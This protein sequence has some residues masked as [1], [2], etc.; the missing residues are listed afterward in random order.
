M[1]EV[2]YTAQAKEAIL[3]LT[4]KDRAQIEVAI[5]RL[6]A[7]PSLGKRLTQQLS[8]FYSYR[9]GVY[10]IIYKTYRKE[11]RIIIFAMGHRKSVYQ[12]LSRKLS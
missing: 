10:R 6:Q 12:T 3:A 1:Y 4:G 11:L 5:H 7:D 2:F 9:T 8:Q